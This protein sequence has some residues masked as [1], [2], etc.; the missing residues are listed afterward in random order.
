MNNSRPALE[1]S[2]NEDMSWHTRVCQ[3]ERRNQTPFHDT[4]WKKWLFLQGPVKTSV[5]YTTTSIFSTMNSAD[6]PREDTLTLKKLNQHQTH[7]FC[8]INSCSK[9]VA[10]LEDSWGW[11]SFVEST[12]FFG[13]DRS[14]GLFEILFQQ[15]H[16]C[17]AN[18]NVV[19]YHKDYVVAP[20]R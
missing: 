13:E 12:P 4:E 16:L 17:N 8:K 6:L 14:S 3:R 15:E 2:R 9:N 18:D 11:N 1:E 10:S 5:D 19:S 20:G 7:Y